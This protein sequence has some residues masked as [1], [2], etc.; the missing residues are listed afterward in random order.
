MAV[1]WRVRLASGASVRLSATARVVRDESGA[2][3]GLLA[4]RHDHP[5]ARLA[6][7]LPLD[8][9]GNLTNEA[10]A[11]PPLPQ[12]PPALLARFRTLKSLLT[13]KRARDA[14]LAAA[15]PAADSATASAAAPPPPL[16]GGGANPAELGAHRGCSP[17]F[18]ATNPG[19]EPRTPPRGGG[20][21]NGN[22]ELSNDQSVLTGFSAALTQL[23]GVSA[24]GGTIAPPPQRPPPAAPPAGPQH[25]AANAAAAAAAAFSARWGGGEN[26]EGPAAAAAAAAAATAFSERWQGGRQGEAAT[27]AAAA[28]ANNWMLP[29][30]LNPH[31]QH[32]RGAAGYNQ[33][34]P[35]P[36]QPPPPPGRGR[37][38]PR[39]WTRS[40][41]R[42]RA[43][44]SRRRRLNSHSRRQKRRRR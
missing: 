9:G 27:A 39:F 2:P 14:K 30:H 36:P 16:S 3:L 32:A 43:A 1:S 13:A 23:G 26:A 37:R 20:G 31:L 11:P 12:Q 35:L 15:A 10:G 44:R 4:V 29:P 7:A 42:G 24:G 40:A 33:S 17:L 5:L 18:G 41:R 34:P 21:G 25:A 38:R 19:G 28:A 6:R 8:E 22:G